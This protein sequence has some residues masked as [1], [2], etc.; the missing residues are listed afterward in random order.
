MTL[1]PRTHLFLTS[2]GA[3]T[4]IVH[5]ALYQLAVD[6][7][8]LGNEDVVCQ[9]LTILGTLELHAVKLPAHVQQSVRLLLEDKAVGAEMSELSSRGGKSLESTAEDLIRRLFLH[10]TRVY[11]VSS[12]VTISYLFLHAHHSAYD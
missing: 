1:T 7:L 11:D 8:T 4:H 3:V 12:A 10:A 5:L 2:H 9:R 6:C